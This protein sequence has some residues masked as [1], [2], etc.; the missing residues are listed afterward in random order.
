[1]R[2]QAIAIVFLLATGFF[3][4]AANANL[5]YDVNRTV[6][7]GSVVGSITTDG[8]LGALVTGSILDWSLTLTDTGGPFF[9][10]GS[11]YSAVLVNGTAFSATATDLLFDFGAGSGFVLFQNPSIGSSQNFWCINN[12]GCINAFVPGET[13]RVDILGSGQTGEFRSGVQ[14]IA[15]TVSVP[16]PA[17]LSL[18]GAGL[19][20]LGLMRRRRKV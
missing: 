20:G 9:L 10:N 12:G 4:N 17:T 7:A 11:A 16:E 19:L 15:S 8:S 18:L 1:M 5:I 13:V 6:G 2:N 14:S 3:A